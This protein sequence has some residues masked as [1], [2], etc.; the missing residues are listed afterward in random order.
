[1]GGGSVH[2]VVEAAMNYRPI[3]DVWLLAR[4]KVKFYGAYPAGFLSRARALLGVAI[5]D[6]VLHVC[7]GR[8]KDY[9]F[10]GFGPN[11]M[12]L[13]LDPALQPDFVQ[14]ARE[15]LPYITAGWPA[16]LIDPPYTEGDAAR[17]TPGA[18]A[19]P[20]PALLLRNGLEAVR[21]GGR[22]GILH[23]VIPRPPKGTKLVAAV[24]VVVGFGNRVRVYSVFERGTV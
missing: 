1:L 14:D 12:T 11:D 22:V 23:Y 24:M 6:P 18:G 21:P 4:S 13:D 9:P 19:L 16:I 8:V 7:S 10:A 5:N 15:G 20:S 2:L 3:T 17:Y